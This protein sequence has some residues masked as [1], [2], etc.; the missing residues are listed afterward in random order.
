MPLVIWKG[1]CLT[2]FTE[3][4]L[5]GKLKIMSLCSQ[6]VSTS[7]RVGVYFSHLLHEGVQVT[8]ALFQLKSSVTDKDNNADIAKYT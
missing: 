8:T 5:T 4:S 2:V 1:P 3:I 6:G 7:L